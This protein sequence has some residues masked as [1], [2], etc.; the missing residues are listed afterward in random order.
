[1]PQAR[2]KTRSAASRHPGGR[3]REIQPTEWG[4]KVERL[5][6]DAGLTRRDLAERSGLTYAGL[7]SL[8]TGRTKPKLETAARLATT[9]NVSLEKLA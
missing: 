9:L 4:L 2:R 3:P 1:M 8:L 6:A 5:A 7:W